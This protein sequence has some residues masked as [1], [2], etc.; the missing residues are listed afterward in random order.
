M[1]RLDAVS[2]KTTQKIEKLADTVMRSVKGGQ[3]PFLEIPIRSLANVKFNERKRLVELGNQR[4]KRYF[5]NVSMAKKFMQT[6]LVSDACKELIEAGKTNSIR[7]LYYINKNNIGDKKQNTLEEQDE[8][9]QIIEDLE[10]AVDALREELHL[11]A[12]RKGSMVGP[13]TIT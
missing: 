5:F 7:D 6:F 9:D 11:F 4:Q 1:A 10:V 13:I 3:N 12:A 8:S 2:K